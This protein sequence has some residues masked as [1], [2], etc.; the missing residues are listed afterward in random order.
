MHKRKRGGGVEGE[1]QDEAIK[2]LLP[3]FIEVFNALQLGMPAD[4]RSVFPEV[5][6]AAARDYRIRNYQPPT[7]PDRR[8][9]H[10]EIK[11]KKVV[12]GQKH[13][14]P[15]MHA[16]SQGQTL[17]DDFRILAV[18]SVLHAIEP[19]TLTMSEIEL[20]LIPEILRASEK[21]YR[22]DN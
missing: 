20:R 21:H 14:R 6:E 18:E 13:R 9:G 16:P 17:P 22:Q 3:N 5:L 4:S 10:P 11:K 2:N 19:V 1:V 7:E 8:V 12:K 15:A